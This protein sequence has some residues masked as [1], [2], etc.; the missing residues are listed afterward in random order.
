MKHRLQRI[1]ELTAADLHDPRTRLRLAV[2]LEAQALLAGRR[3]RT[4]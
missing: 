3:A 1:A 2:A 4:P